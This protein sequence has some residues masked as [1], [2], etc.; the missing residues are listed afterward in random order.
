MATHPRPSTKAVRYAG[1]ITE[2]AAVSLARWATTDHTGTAR[3]LANL[4]P[5][6]LYD[7]LIMM[8]VTVLSSLLGAV[9]SAALIYLLFA[10]GLPLLMEV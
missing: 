6:G 7:T 4:P 8:A 9:I 10:Y 3:L 2:K 1:R 5:M